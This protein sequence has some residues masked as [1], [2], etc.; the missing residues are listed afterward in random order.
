MRNLQIGCKDKHY[1]PC[2]ESTIESAIYYSDN[3]FDL[4]Y[5]EDL[6]DLKELD[7]AK[8]LLTKWGRL[9]VKFKDAR[10]ELE[11]VL[12]SDNLQI[13]TS[14]VDEKCI[15]NYASK[16]SFKRVNTMRFNGDKMLIYVKQPKVYQLSPETRIQIKRFLRIPDRCLD[17]ILLNLDRLIEKDKAYLQDQ[18]MEHSIYYLIEKEVQEVNISID[19]TTSRILLYKP[20][21][22]VLLR[23]EN[24]NYYDDG[25][26]GEFIADT[27]RHLNLKHKLVDP[28]DEYDQVIMFQDEMK[29]E[30]VKDAKHP[31]DR[32]YFDGDSNIGYRSPG[33]HDFVNHYHVVDE[34]LKR[35]P[36]SVLELGAGRGYIVKRLE[37]KG[38]KAVAM[39]IAEHCYHT[40]ATNSFILHD[41]TK[42]PWEFKDNEFDLC[43]SK[44]FF[45]HI[46][47]ND[48]D[49]VIRESAR[50]SKRGLHAITFE[51]H[52]T[53]KDDITHQTLHSKEWWEARFKQAA[54]NYSVEIIDKE[55][56]QRGSITLPASEGLLKLNVGSFLNMYH[57]GWIN[58]DKLN[59]CD[60]AEAYGYIF[61]QV[62]VLK[63]LPYAD[64]SVDI[65][66]ASHIIEH[67]NRK[68]GLKFLKECYRVMKEGGIIRL[69][70]PDG[71]LLCNKYL[72]GTLNEYRFVNIGVENAKDDAESL[73]QLLL[74]GHQTIYDADSLIKLLEEVGFCDVK[75]LAFGKSGSDVIEK[76]TIDMYPTL[77]CYIEGRKCKA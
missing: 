59:L 66:V 15:E 22:S 64:N 40:R 6:K 1:E 69:A 36:Q 11:Q 25:I 55:D 37:A 10:D 56:L 60:Y 47:E 30:Q 5:I 14:N 19:D 49:N 77:S 76:Q 20:P 70:V 51:D 62:D 65:I 8:R 41:A 17:K 35:S 53:S 67:W 48:I 23:L 28:D 63:G 68:E 33:Y 57:Y 45:E 43:F 44:D 61:K 18:Y 7:E 21:L 71:K 75:S 42:T 12:Y 46:S 32:A 38:V 13:P 54:P 34:I 72:D 2:V 24:A 16:L 74:A 26:H 73:F 31:Y 4:V 9:L 3:S 50:V 39:D 27:I 58:I 29:R 52:P